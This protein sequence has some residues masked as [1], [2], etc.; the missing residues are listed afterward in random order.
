MSL[1]K[2]TLLKER[3]RIEKTLGQGGM[4][5]VYR[6]M[7]GVLNVPVAVK[8]NL[9]LAE[10]YTRQFEREA[11]ILASLKHPS[12]PRVVDFCKLG[13]AQYLVMDFIEGEDLRERIERVGVLP[14]MEV[15]LIGVMICDALT[16]LHSRT[17]PV[18]HRDIKPGNIKITPTGGVFLVDFGLAKIA[19][20]PQQATITGARAMTPGY[21]PPE[22]YGTARTDARTDIYALGATLYAG[23]TSTIPE[24][25]L[26][27]F[28]NKSKLSRIR[29]IEPSVHKELAKTV[30]KAL[31]LDADNRFQTAEEFKHALLES[32][33]MGELVKSAFAITPP[34]SVEDDPGLETVSQPIMYGMLSNLVSNSLEQTKSPRWWMVILMLCITLI[35]LGAIF[36]L[37]PGKSF[38]AMADTPT[39]PLPTNT[40]EPAA[41]LTF[42]PSLTSTPLPTYTPTSLPTETST[43]E[44]TH[45]D[46]STGC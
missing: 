20:N 11:S 22:Q 14:E 27:R 44:P 15:I 34:P 6:A 37:G 19:E 4:G 1:K 21:S 40:I 45:H 10:E 46:C 29:S 23:L 8:E 43:P 18:I 25:A 38:T 24:D 33:R 41:S 13:R 30:E 28:T 42:T 36:F 31:E 35:T 26:E 32:G 12:L 3:Y 5:S 16:Y 9:N 7:D 39:M 17:P 2:G